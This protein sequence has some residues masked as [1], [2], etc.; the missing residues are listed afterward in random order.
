MAAPARNVACWGDRLI[1]D[2]SR[3]TIGSRLSL[4][5]SH[6]PTLGPCSYNP[7]S[8]Y[9]VCSITV[10]DAIICTLVVLLLSSDRSVKP[11]S[12]M[13]DDLS[14]LPLDA[15]YDECNEKSE[16]VHLKQ[17]PMLKRVLTLGVKDALQDKMC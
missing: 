10:G 9:Q 6:W 5:L 17:H 3:S 11:E 4:S 13:T 16:A 7:N 12:M 8:E 15:P 1:P 2:C 14:L